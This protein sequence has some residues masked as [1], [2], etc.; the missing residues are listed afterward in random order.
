MKAK[1]IAAHI[2]SSTDDTPSIVAALQGLLRDAVQ[3]ARQRKTGASQFAVIRE[4]FQKWRAVCTELNT[5]SPERFKDVN[6]YSG[7]FAKGLYV[8]SENLYALCVENRV[9]LG[10]EM[11]EQDTRT[12]EKARARMVYEEQARRVEQEKDMFLSLVRQALLR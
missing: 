2:L 1:E 10:Y 4:A 12:F 8:L 6:G 11:D 5:R 3:L 9:L 7:L